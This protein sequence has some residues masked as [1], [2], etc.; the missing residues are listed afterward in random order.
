[1]R[2]VFVIGLALL[3]LLSFSCEKQEAT[4]VTAAPAAAAAAPAFSVRDFVKNYMTELANSNNIVGFDVFVADAL[5]GKEMYVVDIRS[6]TDYAKGHIKGAVN[7]PWGTSAMWEAMAHIPT[8]RTVYVHCY[9]GQTA[10]Q[11]IVTMKLA[12]IKT[13][14]VNSGWNLGISKVDGYDA[15]VTTEAT[16]IDTSFNNGVSA[17]VVGIIKKYYEDT[18]KVAGTTFGNNMVSEENAKAILDAA[19]ASVQFVSMRRPDDYAKGHVPTAINFPFGATMWDGLA[20]L[21]T[22]KK[23]ISYCYSG[24]TANQGIALLRLLGYDAVSLRF[25]MGNA[26]TAPGG[27]SNKGYPVV[28][29]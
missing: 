24:Q 5:A 2:K 4:Q 19:D 20:N 11:A 9:T 23:L 16:A 26:R 15:A 29:D 3:V 12:G 28:T 25:G 22:G 1:M 17:E 6:A 7:V 8:D 13:V 21:P 10:G 18:A 14:S 27:W